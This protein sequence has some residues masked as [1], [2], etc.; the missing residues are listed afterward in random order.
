MKISF[1]YKPIKIEFLIISTILIKLIIIL[2]N[3][4]I[5]DLKIKYN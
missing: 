5:C 3:L 4:K 2:K 1:K